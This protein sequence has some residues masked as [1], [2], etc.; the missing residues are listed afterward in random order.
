IAVD[1]IPM[2]YMS[3]G[4][5]GLSLVVR[6]RG[7]AMALLPAVRAAVAG[8]GNDQPV[9]SVRRM[10]DVIA[11][12][13]AAQ[14]FMMWLLT[15]FAGL[16]V[17]L[18]GIGVYGVLAYAVAQRTQ[19]VGIRMALGAAPAQVLGMMLR[20]GVQLAG[21]GAGLGLVGALLTTRF[22]ASD[23]YGV[24]AT[25]PLTLTAATLLLL[26]LAALASFL[27]AR[28]AAGVDPIEALR[29]V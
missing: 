2:Q 24:K 22:L 18:A 26:A 17:V 27:P 25:D 5:H 13:L 20:Q 11:A 6:A 10:S 9:Y 21:I 12:S 8:A 4:G 16:A 15:A 29:D 3:A 19:E 7:D 1:Q 14:R 28:R 23:L